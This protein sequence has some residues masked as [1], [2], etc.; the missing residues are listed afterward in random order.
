MAYLDPSTNYSLSITPGSG[1]NE[2]V[3]AYIDF[4]DNGVFTDSGEEIFDA[5]VPFSKKLLT[6]ESDE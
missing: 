5:S 4:N 1:N 6:L 2:N 3:K